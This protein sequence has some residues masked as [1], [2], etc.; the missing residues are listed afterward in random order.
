MFYIFDWEV[1][2]LYWGMRDIQIYN[3]NNNGM[4]QKCKQY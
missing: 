2:K 4:I 3:D 1:N